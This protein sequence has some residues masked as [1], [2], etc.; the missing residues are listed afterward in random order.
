MK[1]I[2]I[3]LFLI[4]CKDKETNIFNNSNIDN[5]FIKVIDNYIAE[6]P[7]KILP[8][9]IK[10]GFSYPSYHIYFY[11][12]NKDTIMSII[13]YPHLNLSDFEGI[14]QKDSSVF[15]KDLRPKK[16]FMYK[17]KYPMIFFVKNT[18]LKDFIL[19]EDS[20]IIPDSLK[21][22]KINNHFKSIKCNY[23]ISKERF[24]RLSD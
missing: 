2:F 3:F 24:I 15:Y 22:N 21:Y 7:L 16:F 8:E 5:S 14:V 23:K 1:Y 4:S 13:Q 6:N 9:G 20:V 19:K 17:K 10:R 12:K 11:Q 18:S